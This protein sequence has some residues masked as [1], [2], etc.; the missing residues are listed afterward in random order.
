M[1][2]L[3][4]KVKK[5]LK[6]TEQLTGLRCVIESHTVE[7]YM[8]GQ[9]EYISGNDFFTVYLK[10]PQ[11]EELLVHEL[12]HIHLELIEGFSIIGF[13]PNGNPGGE[14]EL[15]QIVKLLRN[16]TDDQVVAERLHDMGYNPF[17]QNLFKK[18]QREPIKQMRGNNPNALNIYYQYGNK[19]GELFRAYFYLQTEFIKERYRDWAKSEGIK[20]I[21]TFQNLFQVRFRDV[22]KL[23]NKLKIIYNTYNFGNSDERKKLFLELIKLMEIES[24]VVLCSFKK[25]QKGYI[26]DDKL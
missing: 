12:I 7:D 13:P 1:D 2:G 4:Q 10:N 21:D 18:I 20:I 14:S 5:F 11:D 25:A 8:H 24:K 16:Y 22:F 23:I 17:S 9:S 3:S 15:Y 6:D 26:L 19:A